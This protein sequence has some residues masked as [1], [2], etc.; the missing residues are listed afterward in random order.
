M[1]LDELIGDNSPITS[2]RKVSNHKMKKHDWKWIVLHHPH[3]L[4]YICDLNDPPE[5]KMWITLIDEILEDGV[6]G[7]SVG[8]REEEELKNVREELMDR[9]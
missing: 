2:R 8:E 6:A 5:I 3:E 1:G 4:T 7:V 9:L